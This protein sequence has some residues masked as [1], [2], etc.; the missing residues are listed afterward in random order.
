V[1]SLGAA[2]GIEQ[3]IAPNPVQAIVIIRVFWKKEAMWLWEGELY[4]LGFRHRSGHYWQC[5]RGF[6]LPGHAYLSVFVVG[7][8]GASRR[9]RKRHRLVEVSAFH[10]TFQVGVDNL[11][12]YYHERAEGV[13]EPGGHTSTP[14]IRRHG[15]HPSQLREEADAIAARLTA[16]WQGV[17]LARG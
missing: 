4:R 1:S 11:H 14:E 3:V 16:A 10:V 15:C 17:L 13:W 12:F 9:C 6:G 2:L 5:E 7:K 8:R